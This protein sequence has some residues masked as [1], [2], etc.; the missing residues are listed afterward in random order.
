MLILPFGANIGMTKIE[1]PKDQPVA[2]Y[3]IYTT[4]YHYIA[5]KSKIYAVTK[6]LDV[7]MEKYL[8][9]GKLQDRTEMDTKCIYTK[10][11]S[12]GKLTKQSSLNE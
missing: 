1:V 3:Q 4:G 12:Q 9:E 6:I 11:L 2:A 7:N 5:V 8:V 10:F